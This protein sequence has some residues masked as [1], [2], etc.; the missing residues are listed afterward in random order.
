[1]ADI[2]LGPF[3]NVFF[4]PEEIHCASGIRKV[5]VPFPHGNSHISYHPFRLDAEEDPVLYIH[6][7]R[8]PTIQ[9]RCIDPNGLPWKKPAHCQRLK[10]SLAKPLLLAVNRQAI[11]SRKVIEGGKGDD[12]I[13]PWKYPGGDPS[14]KELMESLATL[15]R[16]NS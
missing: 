3:P 1:M 5:V 9:T 16:R 8:Q 4:R 10:R 12:R 13:R 6:P 2:E 15:F 7:D 14:A 11:L